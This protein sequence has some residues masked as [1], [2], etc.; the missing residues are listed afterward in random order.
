MN[1]F[2]IN[3]DVNTRVQEIMNAV[4]SLDLRFEELRK[5]TPKS[6]DERMENLNEMAQIANE[7]EQY[8]LEMKELTRAKMESMLGNIDRMTK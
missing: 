6:I 8:K 7:M 2:M 5:R 1:N 3:F 4:K